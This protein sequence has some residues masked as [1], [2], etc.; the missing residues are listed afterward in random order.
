MSVSLV[1]HSA[2]LTYAVLFSDITAAAS[3]PWRHLALLLAQNV[4]GALGSWTAVLLT[5]VLCKDTIRYIAEIRKDGLL[6]GGGLTWSEWV[7]AQMIAFIH[8][9]IPRDH[10]P[11]RTA[12]NTACIVGAIFMF[13]SNSSPQY[14]TTGKADIF[15]SANRACMVYV[16]SYLAALLVTRFQFADIAE[17][18]YLEHARET[19]QVRRVL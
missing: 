19:Q 1:T 18:T 5:T 7:S 15:S 2:Y 13:V 6:D 11:L 12:T 8:R 14:V 3:T 4:I 9:F 17:R 16:A 10:Q